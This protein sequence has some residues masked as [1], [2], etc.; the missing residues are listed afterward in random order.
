M[1]CY[2]CRK[3]IVAKCY[4]CNKTICAEHCVYVYEDKLPL[5]CCLN[6]IEIN[7]LNPEENYYLVSL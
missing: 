2:T 5:T 6:C 3:N 1:N 7:K 4:W